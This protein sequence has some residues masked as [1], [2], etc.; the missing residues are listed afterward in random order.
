MRSEL[1]GTQHAEA[2]AAQPGMALQ[3]SKM[4]KVA[5][6]GEV[7]DQIGLGTLLGRTTG[8]AFTMS[9]AGS[10][11]VVVQ[12]A[13]ELPANLIGGTGGGEQAGAGGIGGMLGGFLGR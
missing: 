13:E 3:N 12:P 9:F 11:F 7:N 8:E 2:V 6:D 4:L 1:F 10:G 5:L